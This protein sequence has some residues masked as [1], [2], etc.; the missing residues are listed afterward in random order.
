MRRL[1]ELLEEHIRFEE[2][3]LFPLI[4]DVA[5]ET[6]LR[7]LEE[8][9]SARTSVS[10]GGPIWG[11]ETEDLNATLLAWPPGTGPPEHVN[12][13][14][15]VLVVVLDGSATVAIDGIER[16]LES[17]EVLVIEKG[18]SRRISAGPGGVR[19]LAVHLRRSPLQI[20]SAPV[21]P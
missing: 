6:D 2:R 17:G 20:S 12:A 3:M 10:R 11:T 21:S 7:R 8:A 18:T 13:Q 9:G 4:E 14:R 15:D 5:S 1:G 19:Y 16:R